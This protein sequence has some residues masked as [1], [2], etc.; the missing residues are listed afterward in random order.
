[1][2]LPRPSPPLA[3]LVLSTVLLLCSGLNAQVDTN[4]N[5][6]SDIWEFKFGVFGILEA[7]DDDDGDGY[8]NLGESIHG[9]DPLDPNSHLGFVF[10]AG[11]GSYHFSWTGVAE[12]RYWVEN[13][14][15]PSGSL[16]SSLGGVQFGA[17]GLMN[18]ATD[19]S[20]LLSVP[21][22]ARRDIFNRPDIDNLSEL[23]LLPITRVEYTEDDEFSTPR[24]ESS[25][26]GQ[27]VQAYLIPPTTGDYTF[28]FT[29]DDQGELNLSSDT[30]AANLTKIAE[31]SEWAS[32]D[33]WDKFGS[34]VSA[35]ITLQAH[36]PYLIE[37]LHEEW[38]GGDHVRVAWSG[39]GISFQV[40][41]AQFFAG[42]AP[43]GL[44]SYG[45]DW[46]FFRLN[47]A[48]G[49]TDG[50]GVTDW[51]ENETGLDPANPN[52]FGLDD[53]VYLQ[54]NAGGTNTVTV[55][56]T[57]GVLYESAANTTKFVIERR[58]G[59]DPI[60]INYT[61]SG[62]TTSGADHTP[63]VSGS[64]AFAQGIHRAEFDV[65]TIADI[66]VEDTEILTVSISPGAYGIGANSTASV[67][68]EDSPP[69]FF[70]ARLSAQDGAQTAASGVA[71]VWLKGNE[72]Y[73][74]VSLYFS[75]LT[76]TQTAA[77]I[78]DGDGNAIVFS[79]PN[80]NFQDLRWPLREQISANPS[81]E[82]DILD[83]LTKLKAGGLYVNVHTAN[84]AP[85]EIKGFFQEAQASETFVAPPDPPTLPNISVTQ[86]AAS[87]FLNQ[88]SFGPTWNEINNVVTQGYDT[89]ITNQIALPATLHRPRL[90][91]KSSEGISQRQEVWWYHSTHAPDQLRQRIAFALSE[92]FVISDEDDTLRNEQI[93][94]A[95][96]YD[97]LLGHAF[98]DFRQLLEDVTL[99]PM[100]GT[101]LSSLRNEKEDIQRGISPDENFARE[102]QQLLT[103][104]LWQLHPD[105]TAKL[106]PSGLTVPTYDQDDIVGFSRVFTG[107]AFKKE[108]EPNFYWG[109]R[110]YFNPMELYDEFHEDGEKHVINDVVIPAGQGGQQDLD[111]ALDL[112]FNHPNVGPFISRRLIQRLV[113]SNP[114]PGYIYR[115]AQI[116][117][118]NGSGVRGDLA[119]VVRAI[120]LDYEAR[121][122]DHIDFI[123]YGHLK[124]PL[125]RIVGLMRAF[126]AS[127]PDGELSIRWFIDDFGQGPMSSPTVF[128]FFTPD[129]S[130]PGPLAAAGLNSPEFQITSETTAI[131]TSNYLYYLIHRSP[132]SG[133]ND[134]LVLDL[135]SLSESQSAQPPLTDDPRALVDQL[136]LLLMGGDMT[137]PKK[138][139]IVAA[140]NI[141]DND[142]AGD[143]L[144]RARAALHL[145]VTSPEYV[146]QK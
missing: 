54:R 14:S 1:V 77:H 35:P 100:M 55:R 69:T 33:E 11:I 65:A 50:D 21:G 98:G 67:E 18:Y 79:L 2:T 143:R 136:D 34:Q 46:R 144:W 111:D 31:V 28:Y 91:A 120:L 23:R 142:D 121:S 102:I 36:T 133:D 56:R 139:E 19:S 41:P 6:M 112:L 61:V 86:K 27:R 146:V 137:A 9:T 32:W 99:S 78:H 68:F 132:R 73:A 39:P 64:I 47:A 104:G 29:S 25:R 40:I 30:T 8:S 95:A 15:A 101:Y 138:A 24:N 4:N 125:V 5:Q 43:D 49:D 119:A 12:K 105:G 108:P 130:H 42:L 85:G 93:A 89:W 44:T 70:L 10:S 92:I 96:Y 22:Q 58:G 17:D 97:M 115:V 117:D 128:N 72:L 106:G 63:L 37:A 94:M 76:S 127:Q 59:Y 110:D 51:E 109:D 114:S 113:T 81:V 103:I 60:L 134:R 145:V 45:G 7:L 53:L 126:S 26:Y 107:W 87:R 57:N 116:F 88:A 122:T 131:L 3:A 62:T 38:Y 48:D 118:D 82:P 20:T 124:E 13:N 123:G 129:Y 66:K 141:F 83:Q 16:W 140:V 90:E 71:T 135:T 74:N 75:N 80:G 52:T 84:F